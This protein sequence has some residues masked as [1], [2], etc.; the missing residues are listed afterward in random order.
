MQIS[1]ELSLYPLDSDY[2]N[3]VW[4]FIGFLKENAH[5]EVVTNGMSTQVFGDIQEIMPTLSLAMQKIY[6]QKQAILVM[7]MGKDI[8]KIPP[9][10]L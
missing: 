10:I 2:E 4:D 9:T 7:K 1:V 3:I 8:L 6:E 5:L